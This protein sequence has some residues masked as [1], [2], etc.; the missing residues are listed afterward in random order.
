MPA[1]TKIIATVVAALLVVTTA[2]AAFALASSGGAQ[3]QAARMGAGGSMS[4]QGPFGRMMWDAGGQLPGSHRP[5]PMMHGTAETTGGMMGDREEMDRWHERM[6]TD[7]EWMG[8][9]HD[10]MVDR[11]PQMRRHMEDAGMTFGR[12]WA[13]R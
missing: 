4:A 8:E 6:H 10:Q 3:D 5:G 2:S 1:R 9:H 13:A 12:G 7:D 11:Y